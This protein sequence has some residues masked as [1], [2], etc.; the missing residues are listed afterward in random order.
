MARS[1][2]RIISLTMGAE[3]MT[4]LERQRA[5]AYRLVGLDVAAVLLWLPLTLREAFVLGPLFLLPLAVFVL[6]GCFGFWVFA[7]ADPQQRARRPLLVLKWVSALMIMG[8]PL[9]AWLVH[10]VMSALIA[11]D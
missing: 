8:P 2:L 6:L 5:W 7:R 1:N 9:Y 3:Q 10:T 4:A 11:F